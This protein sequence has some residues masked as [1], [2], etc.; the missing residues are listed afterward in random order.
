M[1]DRSVNNDRRGSLEW[2]LPWESVITI[3]VNPDEATCRSHLI[4]GFF[5]VE[6][7]LQNLMAHLCVS[8]W[9]NF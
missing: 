3:R 4:A 7:E 1:S 2:C 9:V 8:N 5:F 6:Q